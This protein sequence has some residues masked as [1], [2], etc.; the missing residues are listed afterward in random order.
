M[1]PP[2]NLQV[3]QWHCT[4]KHYGLLHNE[5]SIVEEAPHKM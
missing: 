2:Y 4:L 5:Q 1:T 3:V